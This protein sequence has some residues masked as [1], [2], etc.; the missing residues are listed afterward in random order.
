MICRANSTIRV[1]QKNSQKISQTG[2]TDSRQPRP[3]NYG[4]SY[5][6]SGEEGNPSRGFRL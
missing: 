3:K 1:I 2:K 5:D 6:R 4:E